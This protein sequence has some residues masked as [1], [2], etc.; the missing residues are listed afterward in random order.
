MLTFDGADYVWVR[1]AA[2]ALAGTAGQFNVT[3]NDGV[4]LIP[5]AQYVPSGPANT[6]ALTADAV[7]AAPPFSTKVNSVPSG[8]GALVFTDANG[9]GYTYYALADLAAALGCSVK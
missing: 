3:W 2:T 6:A 5:G 7:Y 9:G 8:I 4:D 1:D